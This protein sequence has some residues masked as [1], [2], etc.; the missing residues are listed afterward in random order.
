MDALAFFTV[1]VIFFAVVRLMK[2]TRREQVHRPPP[3]LTRKK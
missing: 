3:K 1:L 2:L